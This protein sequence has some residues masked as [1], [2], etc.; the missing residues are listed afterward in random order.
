MKAIEAQN[1]PAVL[2][3]VYA[4][5]HEYEQRYGSCPQ[6]VL[7]AIKDV[8]EIGDDRVCQAAHS[9]AG[10]GALTTKGTCGA[11]IGGMLALG[12][13]H[14]RRREDF[15]KGSF[16]NSYKLSKQLQERFVAE[17]GSPVCADVQTKILGRSFDMWNGKDYKAFEAAG[18]HRD[19]CTHVA[20]MVARW[21]A[22]IILTS[23]KTKTPA[24]PL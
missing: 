7:A 10:G 6:C 1:V 20:G 24:N 14:G 21:A 23:E 9:L 15:D 8:L 11:L 2:D 3:E 13:E 16:V 17:F 5:A 12:A 18:G 22:E 4:R 19:K